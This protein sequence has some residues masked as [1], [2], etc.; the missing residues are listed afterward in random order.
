[1]NFRQD[2]HHP[3]RMIPAPS[4]L[5]LDNCQAFIPLHFKYWFPCCHYWRPILAHPL[6]SVVSVRIFVH[7]ISCLHGIHA[8]ARQLMSRQAAAARRGTRLGKDTDGKYGRGGR[9]G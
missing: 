3:S 9:A 1:M 7:I 6:W 5:L 2:L 4:I 8:N